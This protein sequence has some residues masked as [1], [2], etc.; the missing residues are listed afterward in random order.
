MQ[1]LIAGSLFSGVG[2]MDIG[3]RDAGFDHAFFAEID[4]WSRA[5]LRARFGEAA[6]I[7]DDVHAVGAASAERLDCLAGGFPCQDLSVAG[8]RA[9]LK[10][11]RSGLFWQFARIANELRP[12]SIIIE[13]VEGLYSSG[14]PK[15]ADFGLV[16]DTLAELGYLATWRTLD[17][18][19]FGVPQR[20]RRVFVCAVAASDPA[21]Q[22]IGEILAVAE[23]SDGD[24]PTRDAA[25]PK[26]AATAARRPH[27]DCGVVMT[28]LQDGPSQL[29]RCVTTGQRWDA[30]TEDFVVRTSGKS[31]P[32]QESVI[33][34]SHTQGLDPQPGT[35]T[36]TL[37]RNG[38][39]MAAGIG[40]TVRRLTPL[41]CERLMGWPD[42]WTN[43]PWANKPTSP[44]SRRYAACGNGV[45]APVAYWIGMRLGEVLRNV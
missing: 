22:R 5:V 26:V 40:P 43:I 39:G 34:F 7:Y 29:A 2:G 36:P 44:D 31:H 28:G 35:I 1:K 15:G 30:E 3:L 13:N 10:G 33:G 20:R 27:R 16:L 32:D 37:R 4:E 11:E 23:G 24:S 42:E 19:H 17:A 38:S 45:V 25:W 21:A 14:S 9:G 6:A 18:Q 8:K 41:E 12:R